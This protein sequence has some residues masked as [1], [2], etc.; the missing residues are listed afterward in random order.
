MWERY[1]AKRAAIKVARAAGVLPLSPIEPPVL[2]DLTVRD[3]S[4]GLQDIVAPLDSALNETY[5]WHGAPIRKGLAIAHDDFSLRYVG[6]GAG[7][8][9][10]GNGLYFAESS[11]KAD[12]YSKADEPGGHYE[13][14][15]ALLLCRVCLGRFYY[16]E[17][18]DPGAEQLVASKDFDS[19]LGD[20]ARSVQT[21]RE[22]VLYD[23][24]Q[25]YPEYLVLYSRLHRGT[26]P[27]AAPVFHMELPVYWA[28]VHRNAA[29]EP[30][31]THYRVRSKIKALIERLAVGSCVHQKLNLSVTG[32]Q[33]IEDSFM[34]RRYVARKD[35]LG[36]VLKQSGRAGFAPPNELDGKPESGSALTACLLQEMHSDEAVSLEN[37][38]VAVNE[39]LLWH[40]TT[41]EAAAAIADHGFNRTKV[42]HGQR[43]GEGTYLAEDLG[44]SLSY[45]APNQS[46]CQRILLCRAVCGDFLY[47]ESKESL[48]AHKL[49]KRAGKHSVLA[50]PSGKGPR[51]YVV[52]DVA[53]VYPEYLIEVVVLGAEA[54]TP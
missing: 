39:L 3:S 36:A 23:R 32:V 11:T 25:V 53:Q 21:F 34:W 13:D 42:R 40:G 27:S 51:E 31:R 49:A 50:N 14:I 26:S 46:G 41:S 54:A 19:V 20:R 12:E 37:L 16:T 9:M 2:L 45:A 4:S 15:F 29:L 8:C 22:F 7:G 24:D 1:V 6:T 38:D 48:A 30:F 10:Y 33:R 18:S 28:N 5:L 47:T 35:A 43:F 52:L 17:E 44:K